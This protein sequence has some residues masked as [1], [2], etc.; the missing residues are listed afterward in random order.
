MGTLAWCL[1]YFCYSKYSFQL[2]ITINTLLKWQCWN[3]DF[4]PA[5]AISGGQE[6]EGVGRLIQ[7]SG[8]K[9]LPTEQN[10]EEEAHAFVEEQFKPKIRTILTL[11]KTYNFYKLQ[12]LHLKIK[13]TVINILHASYCVDYAR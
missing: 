4:V 8:P 1:W 2:K 13:T 6:E 9:P 3:G 11:G 7:R 5:K 12:S 10:L